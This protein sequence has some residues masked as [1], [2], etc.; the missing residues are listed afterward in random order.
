MARSPRLSRVPFSQ[1]VL[2]WGPGPL[3]TSSVAA[4]LDQ[5]L[6]GF[7]LVALDLVKVLQKV[8]RF[9]HGPGDETSCGT[10][11]LRRLTVRLRSAGSDRA[12]KEACG[13]TQIP[14]AGLCRRE[15]GSRFSFTRFCYRWSSRKDPRPGFPKRS[16]HRHGKPLGPSYVRHEAASSISGGPHPVGRA[17]RP[18][19]GRGGLR[20]RSDTGSR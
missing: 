1:R 17:L 4:V 5:N 10:V 12:A 2:P 15:F 3:V 6:A 13:H 7:V 14:H 20:S 16:K 8:G 11:G 9:C 19:S 18:L